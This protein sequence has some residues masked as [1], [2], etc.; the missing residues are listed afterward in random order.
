[1][2]LTALAGAL[3]LAAGFGAVVTSELADLRRGL[4][5]GAGADVLV[6]AADLKTGFFETSATGAAGDFVFG[7][8]LT[9]FCGVGLSLT[10][11]LRAGLAV[12]DGVAVGPLNTDKNTRVTACDARIWRSIARDIRMYPVREAAM[13]V[14]TKVVIEVSFVE[15][16]VT[17]EAP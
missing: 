12:G 7:A 5:S 11:A 8:A 6:R 2:A 14:V 16:Q 17:R 1:M 9:V 15:H 13:G 10:L 3:V 4:E